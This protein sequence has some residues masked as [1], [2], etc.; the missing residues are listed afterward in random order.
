MSVTIILTGFEP[1]DGAESNS[2]WDAVS[3]I[4]DVP[5]LVTARLPVEFGR[6]WHEL[7]ALIEQHSPDLVIA[8]GLAADRTA[9]TPERVAIN[10]ADA[11]IADKAGN[12]PRD[13]QIADG[14]DAFFSRLPVT[15]IVERLRG[16]GIA[17]EVSL[18]AGAFVCN[19][20]M[21]RMLANTDGATPVGFI[22]VPSAQTMPIDTI[23]RGLRLAVEVCLSARAEGKIRR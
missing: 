17:A 16:E 9:I 15:A 1:F 13:S 18:S 10:L 22:H 14:P 11:R 3:L 12:Q 8:V 20:L 21:Y 6:A 5:G 4:D 2:S 7:D 23:A 19:D